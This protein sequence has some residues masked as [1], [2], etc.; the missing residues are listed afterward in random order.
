MPNLLIFLKMLF[1]KGIKMSL[2][3]PS[4]PIQQV[5]RMQKKNGS[6]VMAQTVVYLFEIA[7]S[8]DGSH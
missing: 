6:L 7:Q 8:F 1:L 2:R 3:N 5:I 4:Y